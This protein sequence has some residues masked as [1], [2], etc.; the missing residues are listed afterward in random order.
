[1][2]CMMVKAPQFLVQWLVLVRQ[3]SAQVSRGDSKFGSSGSKMVLVQ[4]GEH[5]MPFCI[6][7]MHLTPPASLE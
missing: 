4:M 7:R 3:W 6:P 5:A 2:T 1:M